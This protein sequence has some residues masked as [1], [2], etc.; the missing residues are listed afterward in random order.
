VALSSS[1]VL[2][3]T[4][5]ASAYTANAQNPGDK[6]T[7]VSLYYNTTN[8]A[9]GGQLIATY[10]YSKFTG[11]PHSY[12]FSWPGFQNLPAGTYYLYAVINDGQNPPQTSAVLG[13]FTETSPTPTL[14]A[15]AFLAL[16]PSGTTQQGVFS[17]ATGTALGI[18][19][20]FT[21]P[22]TVDLKLSGGGSLIPAGGT[23][24]TEFTHTYPSAAVAVAALDGLQ[25]ISD[26]TFTGAAT[27]TFTVT[28]ADGTASQVIPLLTPNTHLVVTQ[29]VDSTLPADPSQHVLTV[30]VTNPGGPDGPDGS[31][32]AV[33]NYLSQ[34]L[35]I[36]SFTASQG[37]FNPAT[38]LW[39]IGNLPIKGTN[40]ATL[41][42]TLQAD[43]ST[44]G[45]LV[46]NTAQASSALFN[47]PATDAESIV[48]IKRPH[49]I[50]I[51]VSNLNDS[52]P[53]SLRAALAAAEDGDTVKFSP[54]LTG[55]LALTSGELLI[56]CRCCPRPAATSTPPPLWP[57]RQIPGT[58]SRPPSTAPPAPC[59]STARRSPPPPCP[60][61]TPPAPRRWSSAPPAGTT[62]A[63]SPAA[64][65][66]SATSTVP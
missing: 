27:L 2:N 13:S 1:G 12:N 39:T 64:S 63:T 29:S 34:D 53:G 49:P 20:N 40:T 23:P 17:A 35:S 22:V 25:F 62:A 19:T 57:S 9:V 43:A 60:A 10:P 47:Y 30:T 66:S 11:S 58:T 65:T 44:Q 50:A 8:S 59:S 16:S 48:P 4:L 52:G 45:K 61:A 46:T 51:T 31:N 6:T 37:N 36:L 3:G 5:L 42:L 54:T 24:S 28:T 41:T 32:V 55:T 33:Q 21:Y 15:P 7:T 14:T 38:G 56:P 18:T 26:K